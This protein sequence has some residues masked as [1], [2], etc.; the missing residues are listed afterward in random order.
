VNRTIPTGA[1]YDKADLIIEN[2][3]FAK[4][5]ARR[6]HQ[7]HQYFNVDLDDIEGAALLGLCDAARRFDGSKGMLF[8]TYCY[9]RVRGAMYD[10]LRRGSGIKRKHWASLVREHRSERE[11]GRMDDSQSKQLPY[12]FARNSE[13]LGSLASIVEE[14]GIRLELNSRQ[15]VIGISYAYD[16]DPEMFALVSSSRRYLRKLMQRL[17][18]RERRLLEMRYFS[19]KTF[20]EIQA[21]MDGMSKSW[22]SR[23]HMR[24]LSNLKT[25]IVED[26]VRRGQDEFVTYGR[27]GE[28]HEHTV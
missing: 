20:R 17:P 4:R 22:I 1:R 24:A 26:A 27:G 6:F 11:A 7:H 8:Q 14:V 9:F 28:G 21:S 25:I 13:E 23:L 15:E 10:L 19:G 2:I 16:S 12:V 3:G 18:E 5:A